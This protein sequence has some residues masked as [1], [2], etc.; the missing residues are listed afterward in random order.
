MVDVKEVANK[1]YRLEISI[2]GMDAIFAT[3]LIQESDVVLIEPGPTAAIPS[4][5]EGM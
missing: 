1:V 4:I 3:Y 2:H 5:Q